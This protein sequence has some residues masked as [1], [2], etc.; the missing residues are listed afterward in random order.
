MIQTAADGLGVALARHMLVEGLL[1]QHALIRLFDV[2]VV[3][4]DA[5]YVVF[6]RDALERAEV[7]AFLQ[8]IQ[9]VATEDVSEANNSC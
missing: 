7:A 2:S 1:E 3:V 6:D 4:D 5:F 9:S 8:W